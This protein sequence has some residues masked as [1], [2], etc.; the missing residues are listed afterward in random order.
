MKKHNHDG[1]ISYFSKKENTKPKKLPTDPDQLCITD[2]LE[3]IKN[4]FWQS[5]I[6][7]IRAAQPGEA[8][9]LKGKLPCVTISGLFS[10]R[11][12]E[13]L[14]KHSGFICIDFDG[15]QDIEEAITKLANDQHTFSLFKSASG[16]GLA[17][18]VKIAN[19]AEHEG[20]FRRLSDYYDQTYGLICDHQCG[21]VT[22]LRFAS[23]DKD[24]YLNPSSKAW[25]KFRV[26]LLDQQAERRN[27]NVIVAPSDLER[28]LEQIEAQQI[29]MTVNYDDWVAIGFALASGFGEN[30]RDIFHR[31]SR[32][33]PRYDREQCDYKFTNFL[34][35]KSS[36][37]IQ[38]GTFYHFCQLH[39]IEVAS[40]QTRK[41][42][43]VASIKKNKENSSF[44][45]THRYITEQMGIEPE[46]AK[47]IVRK[48]WSSK[49]V[50]SGLN[51]PQRV[52]L[53]IQHNYSRRINEINE[54]VQI[55]GQQMTKSIRSRIVK[56]VRH[57]YG[58]KAHMIDI[59]ASLDNHED[60]AR[61]HPLKE[62]FSRHQSDRGEGSIKKLCSAIPCLTK[63]GDLSPVDYCYTFIR[64]WLIG[65][66]AG[67]YGDPN[68]L[69][70]ALVGDQNT[71]KT[72]F[73]K[74][75][76]PDELSGFFDVSTLDSHD[77]MDTNL[78]LTGKL[79]VLDD[80]GGSK[81]YHESKRLKMLTSISKVTY[82][83]LFTDDL[84]T[85][86]RLASFCMTSNEMDILVDDTGNRRFIPVH[87]GDN[88]IDRDIYNSLD[89]VSLIMEAWHAYQAGEEYKL[90]REEVQLFMN[91][92]DEF[93][94]ID[95]LEH[96]ISHVIE[97]DTDKQFEISFV[98]IY[99]EVNAWFNLKQSGN[100]NALGRKL[101]KMGFQSYHRVIRVDGVRKCQ[102]YYYAKRKLPGVR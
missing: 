77:K 53:F 5:K 44:E 89:K 51:M 30:G 76:L 72:H 27:I 90:T 39:G 56:D 59:N 75:L 70:L 42:V 28:I 50:E 48:V 33:S 54:A 82:R 36:K 100:K 22:R 43:A 26:K 80:E 78:K 57:M 8:K 6:E 93:K 85:K 24:L 67:V 62:F 11:K 92:F 23:W 35:S 14:V 55:N 73:F 9:K 97:P 61:F 38:L 69:I 84:V 25:T 19:L 101:K 79:I 96:V 12:K 2:F 60:I 37:P 65:A 99:Q 1:L 47:E 63:I 52:Q 17:L 64:K 41:A 94:S 87:I 68:Q 81:N 34:K 3:H 20:S 66:V 102:T 10:R 31:V 40:Q 45:D 88:Y 13:N 16:K 21:D 46:E 58:D 7:A 95:E 83:K 18:I 86:A 71:G 4:G 32:I 15:L 74:H 91:S 49:G 29:D 98:E